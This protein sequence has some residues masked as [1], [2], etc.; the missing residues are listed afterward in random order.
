MLSNGI[1]KRMK[2]FVSYDKFYKYS[3]YQY[4]NLVEDILELW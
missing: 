4:L 3:E 2:S 1:A